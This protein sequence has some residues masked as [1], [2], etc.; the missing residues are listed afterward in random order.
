M[1]VRLTSVVS[2]DSI[3]VLGYQEDY[4]LASPYF[5]DDY[6]ETHVV[7]QVFPNELGTK[8]SIPAGSMVDG[9]IIVPGDQLTQT[10]D[11]VMTDSIEDLT[12]VSVTF[13]VSGL[14]TANKM[15]NIYQAERVRLLSGVNSVKTSD[16]A[17]AM[18]LGNYPNP[19][20]G[21]TTITYSL[22]DRAPVTLVINDVM[23]REV[24]RLVPGENE[25]AGTYSTDFNVSK[26]AT[27]S[28]Q[29]TLTAGGKQVTRMLNVVK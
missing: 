18:S 28:Y 13:I 15:G 2:E 3:E 14:T 16:N 7:R 1:T 19:A 10:V 24:A 22:T 6:W 12:H 17:T 26:L 25:D 21:K 20:N 11:F 9:N 4:R 29:M 8:L 27:G 5:T 23:G